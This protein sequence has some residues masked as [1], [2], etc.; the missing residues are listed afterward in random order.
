MVENRMILGV[1]AWFSLSGIMPRTRQTHRTPEL[2]AGGRPLGWAA[3]RARGPGERR[4]LLASGLASDLLPPDL[5]RLRGRAVGLATEMPCRLDGEP[6][7]TPGEIS[8][9]AGRGGC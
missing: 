7:P 8:V 9:L 2:C 1:H 6:M 3:R 5:P 4:P